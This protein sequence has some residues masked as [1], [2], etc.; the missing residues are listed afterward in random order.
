MLVFSTLKFYIF[1]I[2]TVSRKEYQAIEEIYIPYLTLSG[3][4]GRHVET[5]FKRVPD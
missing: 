1:H 3:K 4:Y 5:G 2:L